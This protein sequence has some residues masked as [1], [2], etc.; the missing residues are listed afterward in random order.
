[1]LRILGGRARL[2]F[3]AELKP[4]FLVSYGYLDSVGQNEHMSI[5]IC[6]YLGH[7]EYTA[8]G[9]FD[10]GLNHTFCEEIPSLRCH[11]DPEALESVTERLS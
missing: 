11:E 8:G 5:A 1:M 9:A 6:T 4:I 2:L 10:Q 7:Q 3:D